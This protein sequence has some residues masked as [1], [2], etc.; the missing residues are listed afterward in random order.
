MDSETNDHSMLELERKKLHDMI[1][2][3]KEK[4][5]SDDSLGEQ[6]RKLDD[7]IASIQKEWRQ[8]REG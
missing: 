1:D 6:S 7:R 4:R 5:R 2:Q 8:Q 3:D